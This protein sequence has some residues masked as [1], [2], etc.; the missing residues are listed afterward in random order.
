MDANNSVRR[1]VETH[2]RR[3]VS[4]VIYDR[5]HKMLEGYRREDALGD[6]V[7]GF[8]ALA[9]GAVA[10]LFISIMASDALTS[11]HDKPMPDSMLPAFSDRAV[12]SDYS[13]QSYGDKPGLL[14]LESDDRTAISDYRNRCWIQIAAFLHAQPR[15][16]ASAIRPDA[17]A[18]FAVSLAL[19]GRI[20]GVDL[21]ESSGDTG[22]A[23]VARSQLEKLGRLSP[24][25]VTSRPDTK[26]IVLNVLIAVE[27]DSV[28]GE[29]SSQLV[30]GRGDET[31][32]VRIVD[33]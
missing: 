13:N 24:F 9:S 22:L 30:I 33:K 25:P 31:R 19:D 6:R 15:F 18:W 21:I 26:A 5:L 1:D 28:L 2:T 3:L 16:N 23:D 4:R 10:L 12:I 20:Q 7:F 8:I 29:S 32:R 27:P 17:T 11:R 14:S